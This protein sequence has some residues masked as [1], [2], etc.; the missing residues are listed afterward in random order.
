MMAGLLNCFDR[1]KKV[2][3]ASRTQLMKRSRRAAF[4]GSYRARLWEAIVLGRS[5]DLVDRVLEHC[6]THGVR[7][8]LPE[9]DEFPK[10]LREISDPHLVAFS[11]RIR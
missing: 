1:R 6:Q 9:D 4:G 10:L 5:D 11:A 2:F 3:E 7:I 8:L